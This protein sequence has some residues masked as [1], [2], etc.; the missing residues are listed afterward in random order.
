MALSAFE[1]KRCEKIVGKYIDGRRPPASMRD[2]LDLGFRIRG[3]S[4]E[5]FEM[6]PAWQQPDVTLETPVA[7]AT[8]VKSRRL[9][10]IYWQRADMRWHRYEPNPEVK[11]L[12][13]FLD[14]VEEDRLG[15]FY[16]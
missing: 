14:V 4:V 6:R 3:Q 16:G 1:I 11:T 13:D 8:Y 15:C 2:Q 7:K 10:K 9:W 5:I 12:E